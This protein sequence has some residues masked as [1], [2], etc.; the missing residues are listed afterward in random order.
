MKKKTTVFV[1]VIAVIYWTSD[2][3]LKTL[4]VTK[5][6]KITKIS[7]LDAFEFYFMIN[8]VLQTFINVSLLI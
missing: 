4:N 6:K 2:E 5:I 8:L 3:S 1:T 7:S